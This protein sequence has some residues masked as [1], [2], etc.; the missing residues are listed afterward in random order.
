MSPLNG[1]LSLEQYLSAITGNRGVHPTVCAPRSNQVVTEGQVQT[2]RAW[3]NDSSG[4]SPNQ[5]S[6][7]STWAK[8]TI[9]S[10]LEKTIR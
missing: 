1:P 9:N 10:L 8:E 6:E 2:D 3:L 5:C 4:F 7:F